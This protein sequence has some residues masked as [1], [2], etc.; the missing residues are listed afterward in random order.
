MVVTEYE[1]MG[2]GCATQVVSIMHNNVSNRQGAVTTSTSHLKE[3]EKRSLEA[4]VSARAYYKGAPKCVRLR[5]YTVLTDIPFAPSGSG[6]CAVLSVSMSCTATAAPKLCPAALSVSERP[7]RQQSRQQSRG[8]NRASS[9]AGIRG[10]SREGSRAGNE[11]A[12]QREQSMSYQS[13]G[14]LF[15]KQN[16][17][18]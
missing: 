17:L 2:F 9:K 16:S 3:Q 18:V 4:A 1:R 11:E 14:T 12:Q 13:Q 7:S 15:C 6:S 5:L 8:G 10:S